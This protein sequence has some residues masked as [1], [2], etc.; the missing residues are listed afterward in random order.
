MNFTPVFLMLLLFP[1]AEILVFIK[2]ADEIGAFN[3]F[4]ACV[5]MAVLGVLVVRTQGLRGIVSAGTGGA[6]SIRDMLNSVL[7]LIAGLL[8]ILPGFISDAF[9]LLLLLPRIRGLLSRHA[10]NQASFAS[11]ASFGAGRF[12]MNGFG[13]R[14]PAANPFGTKDDPFEDGFE[15]RANND[16]SII[17][18][19]FV[20]IDQ[21]DSDPKTRT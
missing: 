21:G 8:F 2:V 14:R 12:G 10:E 20:R 18:G 13:A 4:L 15:R 1:V 6:K 19:D 9:G 5:G 11:A 17:E 16:N 3:T 7:I